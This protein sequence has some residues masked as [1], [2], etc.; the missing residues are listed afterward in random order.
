M[1]LESVVAIVAAAAAGCASSSSAAG[2]GGAEGDSA[3]VLD[4]TGDREFLTRE[5]AEDALAAMF[6]TG[7]VLTKVPHCSSL[8]PLPPTGCA[9]QWSSSRRCLCFR[10]LDFFSDRIF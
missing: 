3:T 1:V 8:A 6:A 9:E 4:L 2:V 10:V 5:T 7:S